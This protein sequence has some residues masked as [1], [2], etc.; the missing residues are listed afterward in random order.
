MKKVSLFLVYLLLVT[1]FTSCINSAPG[2]DIESTSAPTPTE[3][4]YRLELAMIPSVSYLKDTT[5]NATLNYTIPHDPKAVYVNNTQ[6]HFDAKPAEVLSKSWGNPYDEL[7]VSVPVN[8]K[9]LIIK[10][11][12]DI[13]DDWTQGGT[14]YA[15]G[16][17]DGFS[18]VP[19]AT[20]HLWDEGMVYDQYNIYEVSASLET[21]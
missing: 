3:L 7:S 4:V 6:T 16:F 19:R 1:L 10:I 13:N 21:R 14:F 12:Y 8:E 20:V 15:F 18:V 9:V 17:K 2:T 11:I 5:G